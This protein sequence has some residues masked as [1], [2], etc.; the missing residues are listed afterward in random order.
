MAEKDQKQREA[1]EEDQYI[2]SEDED[3]DPTKANKAEDEDDENNSDDNDDEPGETQKEL[4]NKYKDIQGGGLIKTR[5]QRE[6]EDED[7]KKRGYEAISTEE[8]KPSVDINAIWAQMKSGDDITRKEEPKPQPSQQQKQEEEK[9][10]SDDYITITR[11]YKFAGEMHRE[12]KRVHKNSSEAQDYLRSQSTKPPPK[13]KKKSSLQAELDG[14]K[15]KKMNT[16][17]KSRLDWLGFVD[18]E[19]IK[20]DLSHHNKGGYLHKQDFLSRV[21]HNLEETRRDASK[22]SK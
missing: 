1:E 22:K 10:N 16:L 6:E 20:D 14:A 9:T 11:S 3:Y 8:V 15:A 7:K 2:E 19:G 4:E 21:E 17:E 12:E 5:R 13:K 18:Q